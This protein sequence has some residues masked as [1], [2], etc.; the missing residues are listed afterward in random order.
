[1]GFRF[2]GTF[3]EDPTNVKKS[4][5]CFCL[6]ALLWGGAANARHHRGLWLKKDS[7][8]RLVPH[9]DKSAASLRALHAFSLRVPAREVRAGQLITMDDKA[10]ARAV[11]GYK[12]KNPP[13][14]TEKVFYVI[15]AGTQ[16]R[17]FYQL[18]GGHNRFRRALRLNPDLEVNIIV[19][20]DFTDFS[21]SEQAGLLSLFGNFWSPQNPRG[22]YR[23]LAVDKTR[24]SPWRSLVKVPWIK[25]HF[26]ALL[27]KKLA[28]PE[29]EFGKRIHDLLRE[30]GFREKDL[31]TLPQVINAL[32]EVKCELLLEK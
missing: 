17:P 25:K 1:M 30:K 22:D 3:F 24:P 15:K 29:V 21:V 16:E 12:I 10:L 6:S 18:M 20:S 31:R 9:L 32:H 26:H 7:F 27:D 19:V 28:F 13:D 14:F 11:K 4:L 8:G 2:F 23:A 5:F